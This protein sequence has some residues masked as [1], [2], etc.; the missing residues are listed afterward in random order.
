[1][2]YLKYW[3]E[4]ILL[5]SQLE[6]YMKCSYAETI[7]GL[8][9]DN[10]SLNQEV[11]F[12][13]LIAFQELTQRIPPSFFREVINIFPLSIQMIMEKKGMTEKGYSEAF[14]G[15]GEPIEIIR[16]ANAEV[17][18]DVLDQWR[19]NFEYI[20]DVKR[21]E[22]LLSFLDRYFKIAQEEGLV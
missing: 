21:R 22:L 20:R 2:L 7:A 15:S 13:T 18:N 3:G 16:K 1:M 11:Y 14:N 8:E 9:L 4:F 5:D 17:L 6:T 12:R 10:P 19:D